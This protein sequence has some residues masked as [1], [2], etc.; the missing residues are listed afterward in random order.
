[1]YDSPVPCTGQGQVQVTTGATHAS[2]VKMLLVLV[3]TCKCVICGDAII[4][5]HHI[6]WRSL[7]YICSFTLYPSSAESSDELHDPATVRYIRRSTLIT[8]FDQLIY[9]RTRYEKTTDTMVT[10]HVLLL[11]P[12]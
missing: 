2:V 10:V 9:M 8:S 3:G 4:L 5:P 1:M 7:H 11:L 12:F 6:H